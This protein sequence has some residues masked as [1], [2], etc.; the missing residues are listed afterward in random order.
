MQNTSLSADELQLYSRHLALP[1]VAMEGQL[2][3]KK[4]SVLVV[5]TGGLGSP[6]AL[7]LAAAG[8]GRI[9]LVDDDVVEVENLHRQVLF[10]QLD[11]GQP[12]VEA[13]RRHLLE[14]N[15]HISVTTH[16]MRVDADNIHG[17]LADY[18]VVCD[19]TDNFATRYLVNDACVK[20][21][22]PNVF[23]SIT[24]FE[25]LASVFCTPGGP[26][27]R[28]LY[29][30]P[31]PAGSVPSCAEGGVLGVLPGLLGTIQAVETLKILLNIGDSLVGSMLLVDT[32]SAQFR[33]VAIS[34]DPLCPACRDAIATPSAEL[35]AAP[36]SSIEDISD[37]AAMTVQDLN[38]RLESGARP[39]LIDVRQPEEAE[40]CS[41]GGTL[42]PLGEL[43]FRLDEIESVVSA[44]SDPVVVYCKAGGRSAQA[45]EFLRHHGLQN[46]VNL[47]G[48]IVAWWNE[49]DPSMPRY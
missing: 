1:E 13:A 34:K 42:V 3:L 18:D 23:A 2:R 22:K 47:E 29:P 7:Y 17:L 31:P 15:P 48:G 32:L 14:I 38:A 5:G 30:D 16:Q 19:G 12:K 49:V 37:R 26:C 25:G 4:S 43:P 44:A 28:C 6:L 21:G 45:V 46:V 24:Q 39:V 36:D 35:P 10:S 33:R 11:V 41:I 40:I 8:V 27:Y 9:G 20:A